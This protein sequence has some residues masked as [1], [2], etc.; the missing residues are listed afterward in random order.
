MGKR[1]ILLGCFEK[2]ED[3]EKYLLTENATKFDETVDGKLSDAINVIGPLKKNKCR[4]FYG[5]SPT[6]PVVAVVG[7]GPNNAGYNDSEEIDED[8]ENIRSAISVGTRTLRDLGSIDQIDVDDCGDGVA[9]AEGSHLILYNYDELKGES[10]KKSNVNLNHLNVSKD[11]EAELKWNYGLTLAKGQNITRR[12]METPA[13]LMTPTRFGNIAVEELSKLGVK[14]HIRDRAWAESQKMGSFLS[15]ANG[16]DQPPIFLEMHYNNAPNTKPIVFVGKGITFD[17]GGISLKPSLNMDKMRADMGGAANVFG[18]IYTLASLKAS[19]NI[20]GL[21]PL[22]ENMPSGKATKPGDVVFAMNGKSIQIDNTDAE[23]RLVLADALCY[24]HNFEPQLIL[25]IATLTGA[26]KVALGAAMVGVFSTSTKHYNL[27]QKCGVQTGDRVWR[28]PILSHFTKQI[29]DSATADLN[30]IGGAGQGGACVAAAFLKE[31]VTN[32]N[33][34]HLDIA[35]VMDN[36]DDV[37]YLGKGMSGRPMRTLVYF[38]K[39]FFN[40]ELN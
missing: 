21:T 15:V 26:M 7:L 37:S 3:K 2:N 13:N 10:L 39:A 29:T 38:A 34:M 28:M 40:N 31:F 5:L 23:G 8:R 9:A 32:P 17:S 27:L 1:A 30:N 12:L 19:V 16:S 25:D 11:P 4:V 35:G 24:A 33:W 20:I 6:H 14:V 18:T 22:T 36:K